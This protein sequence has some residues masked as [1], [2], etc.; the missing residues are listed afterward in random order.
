MLAEGRAQLGDLDRA[1]RCSPATDAHEGRRREITRYRCEIAH[2]WSPLLSRT[3][4]NWAALMMYRVEFVDHGDNVRGVE[5]IQRATVAEAIEA[6][7]K[8]N[9]PTFFIAGFDA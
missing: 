4:K 3:T 6:A 2:T 9:V 5:R 7:H 8:M 1:L